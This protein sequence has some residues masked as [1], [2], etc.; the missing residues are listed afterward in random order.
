[1]ATATPLSGSTRSP[2]HRIESGER[3]AALASGDAGSA[4]SHASSS[5]LPASGPSSS[6]SHQPIALADALDR[7]NGDYMAALDEILAERNRYCLEAGKLAS[8]NVR[9]WNLMGRIRKDNE[10]LKAI[11]VELERGT[12]GGP[13]PSRGSPLAAAPAILGSF[14]APPLPKRRVAAAN[15]GGI[16]DT[17]SPMRGFSEPRPNSNAPSPTSLGPGPRSPM[18]SPDPPRSPLSQGHS[19][20]VNG[21]SSASASP[22]PFQNVQ[23]H[24]D[25]GDADLAQR[26]AAGE[27]ATPPTVHSSSFAQH[28]TPQRSNAHSAFLPPLQPQ[29]PFNI[30]STSHQPSP[31]AISIIQ[32]RAAAQAQSLALQSQGDAAAGYVD[33]SPSRQSQDFEAVD[34]SS[35]AS[36]EPVEDGA[37]HASRAEES[38]PIA[39]RSRPDPAQFLARPD[40]GSAI[41]EQPASPVT[42]H[43]VPEMEQHSSPRRLRQRSP[44]HLQLHS[45]PDSPASRHAQLSSGQSAVTTPTSAHPSPRRRDTLTSAVSA[46]FAPA[47][48]RFASP[49]LDST[50]LRTV[51]LRVAGSN[52]RTNERGK[53]VISFF[54]T[55]EIL[56]PPPNWGA[57]MLPGESFPPTVWRIEKMYSD[58]LALDARLKQ[59]HGRSATKRIA[60]LPDKTLFKDHAPSKVDQRK[61]SICAS[62]WPRQQS[63]TLEL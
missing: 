48:G 29:S 41:N 49:R 4:T 55:V 14:A 53:E 39:L 38:T 1:M 46:A 57:G 16:L 34:G 25:N 27:L 24:P 11:V 45:P 6:S 52:L 32:Q 19:P 5:R 23:L 10:T 3:R 63:T 61:V 28:S 59:K 36:D 51:N 13:A 56:S 22:T 33:E 50:L 37:A 44:P 8:E 7:A 30:A 47:T 62:K 21:A 2:R 42:R 35:I 58:V 20:D 43:I 54:V 15:E 60:Q 18:L 9:I 40:V 31:A 17:R 12:L 26:A